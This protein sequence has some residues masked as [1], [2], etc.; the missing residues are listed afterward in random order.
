[1]TALLHRA[2]PPKRH[3][4]FRLL[5][6]GVLALLIGCGTQPSGCQPP[7]T[8]PNY[9]FDVALIEDPSTNIVG[10]ATDL[11][12]GNKLVVLGNKASD[13]NVLK[14]TGGAFVYADGTSLVSWLGSDGLPEVV[15][16]GAAGLRLSNYGTD[17]VDATF[18]AP[19]GSAAYYPDLPIDPGILAEARSVGSSARSV[20]NEHKQHSTSRLT[21][22]G[23][24]EWF[25]S[26]RKWLA[27]A[28]VL[29]AQSQ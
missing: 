29:A 13:G 15:I 26:T 3:R 27:I 19:D 14:I 20:V 2:T 4:R 21:Y 18:F 5:T 1:M 10:V 6:L 9:A 17:T 11:M 23:A 22:E 12:S 25:Q 24:L 8:D 16:I 7:A 28:A